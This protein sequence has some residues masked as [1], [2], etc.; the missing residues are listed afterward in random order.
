MTDAYRSMQTLPPKPL[1]G[2]I[3]VPRQPKKKPHYCLLPLLGFWRDIFFWL[4]KIGVGTLYR[5]QCGQV[6]QVHEVYSPGFTG[7]GRYLMWSSSSKDEWKKLGG[8]IE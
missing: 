7:T 8:G 2:L 6:H 1:Y 5:C 3:I 4:P